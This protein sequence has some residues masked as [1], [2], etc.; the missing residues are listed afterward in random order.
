MTIKIRME[1][2]DVKDFEKLMREWPDRSRKVRAQFTYL[3]TEY[4]HEQVRARIPN[5]QEYRPYK[6][7]LVF[8]KVLGVGAD[9]DAF[10][11]SIDPKHSKVQ[12]VDAKKTL[13]YVRAKRR[14]RR[15][16][17]E[18]AVLE[19]YNPWTVRSIPFAPKKRWAVVVSRKAGTS[20][21]RR[22]EKLRAR[23]RVKWQREL[24]KTGVRTVKKEQG[25]KLPKKLEALPDVAL[26]AIRLEF[27]LGMR[28]EPHW[29]PVILRL[30][31]SDLKKLLKRK[32]GKE[33]IKSLTDSGFSKWKKWPK[34]TRRKLRVGDARKFKGFQKRL[35][36]RPQK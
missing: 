5:T 22:V 25:I 36:I 11:I 26:D 19:R 33:L 31:K 13:L 35:G 18:I 8:S 6:Q 1:S 28:S 32:Q 34:K 20:E 4:A 3:A 7:G 9:E 27:G 30:V 17:P 15:T 16:P 2:S 24:A 29:R 14:S 23:D 12:K 21:V 10:A